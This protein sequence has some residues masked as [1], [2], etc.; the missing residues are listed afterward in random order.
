MKK[1]FGLSV[2]VLMLVLNLTACGGGGGGGGGGDTT[3]P[4]VSSTTPADD[5]TGVAVNAAITVTF[6]EAMDDATI[7]D[8]TFTLDNGV[9]GAV[10]YDSTNHIATLTPSANLAYATTYTATITTGVKDPAG[11]AMAADYTWSF[12]TGTA[13][14]TAA[15]TVSS[16][17]PDNNA[18]NVAIN[19]SVTATFNEAMNSSTITTSTFTLKD[20]GNTSVNGA[21]TYAGTT[22]T[23]DP[24]S[25]LAYDT[26][27]TATITM[28]AKDLAGNAMAANKTW[29]FTTGAA[30]DTQA[31]TVVSTSPA[32][33]ATAVPLSSNI[34]ATFSEA[35]NQST[36]T[37]ANFLLATYGTGTAV[38]GTVTPASTSAT[39]DPSGLEPKT[40]YVAAITTGVKDLAGNQMAA[41]KY[42]TF[43]TAATAPTP[44]FSRVN[45]DTSAYHTNPAM[46]FNGSGTGIAVWAE[47]ASNNVNNARLLY[48]KYNGAWQ[49]EAELVAGGVGSY[50]DVASDG[51]GFMVVYSKDSGIYAQLFSNAGVPAGAAA[52]IRSSS[53][54]YNS[55]PRVVSS[56]ADLYAAAWY[57]SDSPSG[58]D[59]TFASVYSAGA[60]GTPVYVSNTA[61]NVY[62]QPSIASNGSGYAVAWSQYDSTVYNVYA[63]ISSGGT[64]TTTTATLLENDNAGNASEPRVASDGSDYAVTWY[65]HDGSV[66]NIYVNVSSGGA[67]SAA[68]LVENGSPA[69]YSPAIASRGVGIYA[70]AWRQSD[71]ANDSIYANVSS[72]G[73]W[74]VGAAKLIENDSYYATSPSIA[75]G[76]TNYG[77]A[78]YQYDNGASRWRIYSNMFSSLTDTTKDSAAAVESGAGDAWS[79]QMLRNGAGFVAVW[80]Q[81]NASGTDSIF[82]N[83]YSGS[84]GAATELVQGSYRGTSWAPVTATNKYGDFLAVWIQYN[85]G[86][87]AYGR[88]YKIG[89][90]GEPFTIGSCSFCGVGQVEVA[91][92]GTD[93]MIT[94]SDSSG[95]VRARTCDRSGNLGTEYD[96]RD[97][98]N[99]SY[100]YSPRVASNGSDY[101]VAW[102]QYYNGL[103]SVYANIYSNATWAGAG[104]LENIDRWVSEPIAIA[105]NSAD[106][107]VSW[108]QSDSTGTSMNIYASMS[109][110]ASWGGATIVDNSTYAHSP[111]LASNGTNYALAWLQSDNIYAN[112]FSALTNT[113]K[114]G[115]MLIENGSAGVGRPAIASNGAGYAAAWPQSDGFVQRIYT[116]VFSSLTVTTKD[117]AA[118]I[119][120]GANNAFNPRIAT[121]GSGYGVAW[122]QSDGSAQS[123]YASKY[124]S[125]AWS[126]Q[127]L[128]ESSDETAYEPVI[129]S[130]GNTY[131]A[132]WR[133]EDPADAMVYDIWTKIGF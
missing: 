104:L 13:P 116:N 52:L 109:T 111:A 6:S 92:N 106:Y 65:Q 117:A 50:F 24:N 1:S 88:L 63:N 75:A 89:A 29:S 45:G 102:I 78:W 131:S 33:N 34:T 74:S 101:A 127:A 130:N 26:T 76:S 46:A 58:K 71:G 103:A 97:P 113:T 67:W 81:R 18:T 86:A 66:Y 56:G 15:P 93:F 91:T 28:G 44:T 49:Q 118:Q 128:L 95:A 42:W 11:N 82:A 17:V 108:Y 21:V 119:S 100:S 121:D 20:S 62:N 55:S 4:T 48:A 83:L 25:D 38:S 19:A 53:D 85:A 115:A 132:I 122:D 43:T 51:A 23:F 7:T 32:D 84:W 54:G 133:Q 39:F 12:T 5:A 96:L 60:W 70:I 59:R 61:G 105:S 36:L 120:A 37:T 47:N 129:T 2:L 125:G 14:D 126:S 64:W 41:D 16:T 90:W 114:D 124:S 110:G 112:I 73:A 27:Y 94:W 77:V 57:G 68:S 80:N 98:A 72:G 30:P 69:A 123:I 31:P 35:M 79:P 9:T 40:K 99:T 107:A 3:A 8:T 10:T 22:A 87:Y